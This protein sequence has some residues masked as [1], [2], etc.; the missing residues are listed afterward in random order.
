MSL[1]VGVLASG[2]GSNAEALWR[3]TQPGGVLHGRAQITT[4]VCDV[5]GAEV[6]P[7]MR[8]L[9]VPV[10]ELA[11]RTREAWETEMLHHA[12]TPQVWA[13]AGFR[14]IL[15]PTFV[16]RFRG[17]ILNIHPADPALYR[18]L[19][20]YAWAFEHARERTT[21]TV[22]LVDEGIDTGRVVAAQEVD[23]RGARTLAEVERRGLQVEHE[24]YPRALCQWILEE[25]SCAASSP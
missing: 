12:P 3:A 22:H 2:R 4:L 11:F 18:G 20:G 19:G 17:R 16:R 1:A 9:D 15:S 6:V 13:L 10:I 25:A 14:R 24:L 23:L 5:P 7:R 21:I 8:A